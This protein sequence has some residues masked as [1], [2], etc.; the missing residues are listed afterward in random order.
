MTWIE[1][2]RGSVNRWEVDNVDH[3]T[4]AYYFS[5]FEDATL[6]L[7][8]AVGAGRDALRPAGRAA[9][10]PAWRVRYRRELRVGDIIHVRSG[11]LAAD[12]KGLL[13]GHEL[14]DSGDDALCTTVVQ[15]VAIADAD[16]RVAAT[17]SPAEQERARAHLVEWDAE[18]AEL[19]A[20]LEPAGD[21]GFLDTARDTV[22]AWEVD[23]DGFAAPPAFIHRFSAANG[24]VLGAFG[25]TPRYMRDERRG[26]ST[27]EFRLAMSAAPRAGDHIRVRSALAH[28][29]S[30][31]LRILH[32][33]TDARTGA[34]MATL[35]QAG[36][37][38]DLAA[39]RPAPLPDA[40]RERARA[41]VLAPIAAD[42]APAR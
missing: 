42:R 17:L 41:M 34:P 13:V 32:R 9:V 37:H 24:H 27:F 20:P 29:G 22:K 18:S 21:A 7:L 12:D 36:V 16:R 2:Y 23:A 33:M 3:F 35:E 6:A 1:T 39:R 28:L 11:V 40:L 10:A 26:L 19:I 8:D 15:R 25:M 31:S 14:I 38:L 30:S 5:R 4:V